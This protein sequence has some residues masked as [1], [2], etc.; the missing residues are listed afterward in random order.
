MMRLVASSRCGNA[1]DSIRGI[2]VAVAERRPPFEL[3]RTG[4]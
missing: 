2:A 4:R 1:S 3:K